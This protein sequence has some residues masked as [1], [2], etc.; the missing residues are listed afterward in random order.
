MV[1]ILLGLLSYTPCL[2]SLQCHYCLPD[3]T[4][5]KER[6]H[7]FHGSKAVSL[8]CGMYIYQCG[9]CNVFIIS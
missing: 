9:I 7:A 5:I 6:E 2:W 4:R 8:V 1:W 3:S